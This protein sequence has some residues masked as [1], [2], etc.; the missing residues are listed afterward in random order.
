MNKFYV[1]LYDKYI[2]TNKDALV[3]GVAAA[4]VNAGITGEIEFTSLGTG[5]VGAAFGNRVAGTTILLGFNGDSNNVMANAGYAKY[6]D[7][8][9]TY[10]TDTNRKLWILDSARTDAATVAVFNY[11]EAS[12]K[13]AA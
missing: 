2:T 6:S 9:Y 4:L 8:S 11:L 7:Q 13:A 5:N 3:A 1:G 12:W 10:G